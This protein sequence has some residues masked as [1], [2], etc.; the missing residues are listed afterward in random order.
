MSIGWLI[1]NES[2]PIAAP[3]QDHDLTPEMR[4]RSY[5][6]HFPVMP[7][8]GIPSRDQPAA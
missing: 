2:L 8:Y 4:I 3:S 7:V 1:G 5:A 6:V